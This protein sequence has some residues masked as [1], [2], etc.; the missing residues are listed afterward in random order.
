VGPPSP[1]LLVR[2]PL[3]VPPWL[4]VMTLSLPWAVLVIRCIKPFVPLLCRHFSE[5]NFFLPLQSIRNLWL[6]K[7]FVCL[8]VS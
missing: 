4:S 2:P 1:S 3:I 7:P 6:I 8:F 5:T